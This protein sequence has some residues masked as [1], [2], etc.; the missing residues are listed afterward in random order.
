MTTRATWGVWAAVVLGMGLVPRSAEARSLSDRLRDLVPPT[1]IVD[2]SGNE[3]FS[4]SDIAT[5]SNVITDVSA[6]AIQRIAIRGVDFPVV[7][8]VPGFS[9]VY[10]PTL[11]TFERSMHL[12]PV[13]AERAET[14]G[15]GR[16]EVGASYLYA[17]LDQVN[18]DDLGQFTGTSVDI[19]NDGGTNTALFLDSTID[20]EEFSI[21]Y[22]WINTSLTY[23]ITDRWDANILLPLVYTDM[24]VRGRQSYAVKSCPVGADG[25]CATP[26][27]SLGRT[28]IRNVHTD[29]DAFGVG[30][31][32]VRT[33]YRFLDGPINVAA[34][35]T[36]RLPTGAEE[37]FQGLGDTTITPSLV[38]ATQL[39]AGF[40]MYGNVGFEVNADDPERNRARYALGVAYQVIEQLALLTDVIGSSSFVDDEFEIRA[41]LSA[42][43]IKN[44]D[45]SRPN[46]LNF[47][48]GKIDGYSIPRSDVVDVAVGAKLS[49]GANAT[50]YLGAIVPVTDDGLRAQVIPTGGIEV[51]F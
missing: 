4:S 21:K 22:H 34:V 11:Q 50:A 44:P 25:T 40:S 18:G 28:G 51:G 3:V 14:L 42:A 38:A 48:P 12:G 7:A 26:L 45:G 6:E 17:D 8:T 23:G 13:F 27:Q 41:P 49:L 43:L 30:D 15:R 10:N 29:G 9:S 20:F 5:S 24:T 1:A 32:L 31:M 39:G 37:D 2:Q 36:L 47:L 19:I 33:K 35:L 46:N 16:F